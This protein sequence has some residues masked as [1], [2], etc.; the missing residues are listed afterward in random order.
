MKKII[1]FVFSVLLFCNSLS[2]Q[3]TVEELNSLLDTR[4]YFGFRVDYNSNL[5]LPDSV[6]QKFLTALSGK[7][8]PYLQDSLFTFEPWQEAAFLEQGRQECKGDSSCIEQTY[9]RIIADVMENKTHFYLSQPISGQ[10]VLAAGSWNIREAIPILENAIGNERYEE[11]AILMALAK[12]GNDSIKQALMEKYTLSYIL[13]TTEL[14][15]INDYHFY[16]SE[17]LTTKLLNEGIN[18][19]MYFEDKDIILNLMDFIHIKGRDAV[20]NFGT[21]YTVSWFVFCLNMYYFHNY[22]NREVLNKICFDYTSAIWVLEDKRRNRREQRE[23][24]RLL[25][26]EYR[27]EIKNQIRDWIIENVNFDE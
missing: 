20:N 22:P 18:V 24:D 7:L 5:T 11:R 14:D 19:A 15:T 1:T 16:G 21:S 3:I 12:L 10:L 2:A 13:Q 17:N 27:T 26:T 4:P 8:T 25:S 6:K 23:L 9:Q